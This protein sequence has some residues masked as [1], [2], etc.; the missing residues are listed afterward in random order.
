MAW[1]PDWVPKSLQGHGF[2]HRANQGPRFGMGLGLE[3]EPRGRV[4]STLFT[5]VPGTWHEGR[6]LTG[7]E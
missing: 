5:A 3:V 4:V 7:A 1:G 2:G 6:L